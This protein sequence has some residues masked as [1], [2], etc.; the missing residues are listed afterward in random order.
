VKRFNSW[1]PGRQQS[2]FKKPL[3]LAEL[4][5]RA[6][7]MIKDGHR[8]WRVGHR[9]RKVYIRNC[10]YVFNGEVFEGFVVKFNR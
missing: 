3:C 9:I 4:M 1:P 10:V 7:K 5:K 8:K 2:G 6:V